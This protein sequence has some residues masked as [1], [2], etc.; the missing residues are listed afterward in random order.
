MSDQP[1]ER[2]EARDRDARVRDIHDHP[3]RHRHNYSG[4][5]ACCTINGVIDLALIE[6]HGAL[7]GRNGGVACDVTQGPCACG[8]WHQACSHSWV[9]PCDEHDRADVICAKCGDRLVMEV[10][11]KRSEPSELDHLRSRVREL[12]RE[13]ALQRQA[14]RVN[15]DVH[16]QEVEHL[17]ARIAALEAELQDLRANKAIADA[18]EQDNV[19]YDRAEAALNEVGRL[20][21]ENA[22]L[23]EDKARLDWAEKH[24]DNA[25][26][27]G[28]G[29]DDKWWRILHHDGNEAEAETL[30]KA[31][32]LA[33]RP[34]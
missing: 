9:S 33:R 15:S 27:S 21:E 18:I 19:N 22:A 5:L 17:N 7:L 26:C 29:A 4:L 34:V 3:E 2:P 14:N 10:T 25:G 12:E 24:L 6:A 1:T 20:R 16:R 11:S 23:R 28:Y 13:L 8:A 30:R 31:L 32:D